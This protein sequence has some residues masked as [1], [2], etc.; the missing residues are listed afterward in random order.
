MQDRYNQLRRAVLGEP[1]TPEPTKEQLQEQYNELVLK[2]S[3]E[4]FKL[5]HTS[6]QAF[7]KS[8]RAFMRYKLKQREETAAML[9]GTVMHCLVLEPHKF[10]EGYFILN[11]DGPVQ[12][13]G[14]LFCA[15]IAA[16][17]DPH[18]AYLASGYSGQ[19]YNKN[20]SVSAGATK[21]I[22]NNLSKY[23]A[24][25]A[26]LRDFPEDASEELRVIGKIIYD[27]AR[28]QADAILM[29]RPAAKLI[30]TIR[31]KGS[32]ERKLE[33]HHRGVDFRGMVDGEAILEAE[34]TLDLKQL[35]RDAS[36]RKVRSDITYNGLAAQQV[37]YALGL[38]ADYGLDPDEVLRAQSI[39][40]A[41]DG[42]LDVTCM[43]VQPYQ[44][45]SALGQINYYIDR[46][47]ECQFMEAWDRSY[48]F[49]CPSEYGVY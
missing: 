8:P 36:P 33:W 17:Y 14:K 24:Y 34:V 12:E 41:V 42:E 40:I 20:G 28:D 49:Y 23:A 16:G 39:V 9:T 43:E 18:E 32:F 47:R 3:G 38:A 25:I 19:L 1:E 29:T 4:D 46:F 11:A 48:D 31:S 26:Q 2:L 30:D 6:L 10:D 7:S 45:A 44:K 37:H 13:P 21:T 27:N 35:G 15:A 22:T 5:S